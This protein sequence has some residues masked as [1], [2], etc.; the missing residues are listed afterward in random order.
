M[1]LTGVVGV[2]V[3]NRCVGVLVCWCVITGVS[4]ALPHARPQRGSADN[5]GRMIC[6]FKLMLAV[7]HVFLIKC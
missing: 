6:I 4:L 3:C 2:L 7:K 1:C 5:V